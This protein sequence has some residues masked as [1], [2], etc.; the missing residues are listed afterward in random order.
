MVLLRY[1]CRIK[2]NLKSAQHFL[3]AEYSY[4]MNTPKQE[5]ILHV[6]I[7]LIVRFVVLAAVS[8]KLWSS[9]V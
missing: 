6:E 3:I 7:I 4:F 1:V 5:Q 8:M 9:G 2:P